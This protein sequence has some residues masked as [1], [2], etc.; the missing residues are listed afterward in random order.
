MPGFEPAPLENDAARPRHQLD[1]WPDSGKHYHKKRYKKQHVRLLVS[2]L[3]RKQNGNNV[4]AID[5]IS[6]KIARSYRGIK[7]KLVEICM[8]RRICLDQR[9]KLS[10]GNIAGQNDSAE[11]T[12][13]NKILVHETTFSVHQYHN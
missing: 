4:S 2:S 6:I 12:V 11:N 10:H 7:I 8:E 3:T 1:F 13:Q 9:F 5:F